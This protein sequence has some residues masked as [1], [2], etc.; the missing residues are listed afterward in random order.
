MPNSF[1]KISKG[2]K[3]PEVSI[4]AKGLLLIIFL[5]VISGLK[6]NIFIFLSKLLAL[7]NI[8]CSSQII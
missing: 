5:N 7:F 4:I 6:Q 1:S 8:F 3:F 2:F